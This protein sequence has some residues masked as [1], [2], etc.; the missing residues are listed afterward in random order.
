MAKKLKVLNAYSGI[1]GNRKFWEDVDVTAVEWDEKIASI[2]QDFFPDDEMIITDAHQF[3]LENF[4]NYDF[5]WSSP[6]CP[7]HSQLRKYALVTRGVVD[8]VYPDMRLYQEIIFLDNYFK[9][10]YCVE[11]VIG[12]YKPLIPPQERGRHY[13]WSN[14]LIREITIPSGEIEKG[15]IEVWQKKTGFNLSKYRGIDKRVI[16]RNC[17]NSNLGK[18]I[19][20]CARGNTQITLLD[21]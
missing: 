2:Y 13:F 18:H 9:G 4:Q 20:D 15:T 6:P 3:L 19:L 16:L 12:Y 8:P 14:F 10:K 5:V 17:V 7:T 11:N 1:G 21:L